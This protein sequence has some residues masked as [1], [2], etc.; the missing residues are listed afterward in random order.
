MGANEVFVLEDDAGVRDALTIVLVRAGYDPIAFAD[1]DALLIAARKRIPVSILLDLKLPGKSGLE[2]LSELQEEDYPAPVFIMSGHGSVGI[3]VQALKLG[4]VDFIEKPFKPHELLGRMERAI[5]DVAASD[6][7]SVERHRRIRAGLKALTIREREILDHVLSGKTT[8][9][10]SRQL[11]LSPRT[12]DEHRTNI[13]RKMK[14]RSA[15][16]LMLAFFEKAAESERDQRMVDA[17]ASEARIEAR[18]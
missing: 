9:E 4:A 12:V 13:M 18:R 14:V 15:T 1:G 10:I 3:A 2:V 16:Q 7:A 11:K 5:N 6:G 8:K 17:D